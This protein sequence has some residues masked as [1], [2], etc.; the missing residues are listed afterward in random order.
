MYDAD[1]RIHSTCSGTASVGIRA[2]GGEV[3]ML[4]ELVF[5]LSPQFASLL[6][7]LTVRPG[8]EVVQVYDWERLL[9]RVWWLFGCV[10]PSP[11]RYKAAVTGPCPGPVPL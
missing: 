9:V 6:L 2:V 8:A 11:M 5:S 7:L 3:V 1:V 4:R 10:M